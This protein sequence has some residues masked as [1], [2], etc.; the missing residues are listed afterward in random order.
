[1]LEI[2]NR[3]GLSDNEAINLNILAEK[4]DMTLN[5]LIEKIIN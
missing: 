2:K 3:Y 5:Q 1:M 4:M